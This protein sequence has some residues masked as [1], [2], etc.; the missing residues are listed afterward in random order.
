MDVRGRLV[1]YPAIDDLSDSA[2]AWVARHISL[3]HFSGYANRLPFIMLS[4]EVLSGHVAKGGSLIDLMLAVRSEY[5]VEDNRPKE[6][7]GGRSK[8]YRVCRV[9]HQNQGRL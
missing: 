8:S 9:T 7:Y 1:Q 6:R 4:K 3:V 5:T 2:C